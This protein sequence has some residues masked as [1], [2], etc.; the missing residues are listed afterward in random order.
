MESNLNSTPSAD[1]IHI[2]FFGCS[3]TG[4]SSLL[5]AI[6]GQRISIVSEIKGTTTDP[7]KKAMEILPIG[8]V[9]IFDTPGLD[10]DSIL[11]KLRIEKTIEVLSHI[12]IAIVVIDSVSGIQIEDKKLINILDRRK[13]PFILVYNKCDIAPHCDLL[14]NAIS[15]SAK[16]GYGIEKLKEALILLYNKTNIETKKTLLGDLIGKEDCIIFVTPIDES[17]PK[18]RMILPQVQALRSALD[19]EA[20][21]IFTQPN[22]LEKT[23]SL[24]FQCPK[25]IVTDS[26][27]FNQ[28]KNI[29]KQRNVP[30][31]SFSILYARYKGFLEQAVYGA[32]ILDILKDGD[33][34]LIS[35]GC[36]HHKQCNDIGTVKLPKWIKTFS[37]KKLNFSFSSGNN[38]PENL[39]SYSLIVHCG[40]CMLN[41]KEIVNRCEQ[42]KLQRIPLTNYGVIIAK[43]NG[44]LSESISML[45]EFIE[46]KK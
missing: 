44:I 3:N 19:K 10:D 25:L 32:N 12:D 2:G 31:T 22:Q 42:V 4:K 37:G 30:L 39:S 27:V 16:T 28:V 45:P 33:N 14:K 38:F 1:R 11:G 15:V 6:T 36:T 18:G 26:Q 17:A 41:E 23:L 24:L 5:N 43:M 9:E 7:V 35:E 8:A 21:C 34:I 29:V 13:I 46:Y 40:G 20:I